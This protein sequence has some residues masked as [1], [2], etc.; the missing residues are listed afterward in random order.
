MDIHILEKWIVATFD[1]YLS[2]VTGIDPKDTMAA[3]HREQ[4]I[5][6]ACKALKLLDDQGCLVPEALVVIQKYLPNFQD[7]NK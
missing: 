3:I 4:L 2:K 7:S 6:A 1:P 5:M